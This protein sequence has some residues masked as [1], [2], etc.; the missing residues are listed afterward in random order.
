MLFLQDF[1]LTFLATPRSQM[2]PTDTLSWK[3]KIGTSND[4][5]DVVL[6]PSVLFIKAINVV[7]ANKITYS[8]LSDLLIS[9]ALYAL[10]DG[11]SLLTRASKHDWHYD[12]GKLY[13]KDRLYIAESAWQ[14]SILTIY[15]SETCGHGGVFHTLNLVQ[16]DYWWPGMTTY[17]CKY[18][19][20]YVICQANKVNTHPTVPA[21]SSLSSDYTHPF[22][23]V[24]VDL[25]TN[26]PPSGSFDSIMIIVDHGLIK[27]VIFC[28]CNKTIDAVGVAKLFFLHVFCH[29]GLHDKCISDQGPQ[30][31]L[32][33]ARELA[34]LLKYDLKLSF[35]SHTQT[36]GETESVNQELET[37]LHIFCNRHSKKWTDLLP[38]AEFSYNSTTHSTTNKS[39]FSLIL[40]YEL[41][42]YSPIGKT[43]IPALEIH[44]RE[45]EE[46]RKEALAAHE[47]AWRTMKEQISSKFC[48]WRSGDKVWLE[49]KNLKLH[50]PSKKLTSRREGPFEITQVIS[51]MA[52][53]LWLPLTWKIHDV[54]HASLLSSYRE[55]SEHSTN[56]SNPPPDLIREE[57]EYKIDKILSHCEIQGWRQ[58]LVSWKEYS[59]AENTWKPER[60]LQH[61]QTLLKA[62]KLWHPKEFPSSTWTSITMSIPTVPVRT[63]NYLPIYA[64]C[65]PSVQRRILFAFLLQN[66]IAT[67]MIERHQEF[68]N[69]TM[70]EL[71]HLFQIYCTICLTYTCLCPTDVPPVY[72]AAIQ[73][74]IAEVWASIL[75]LLHEERFAYIVN[76]L[77]RMA[78]SPILTPLFQEMSEVDFHLYFNNI[79]V[80]NPPL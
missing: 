77:P 16:R 58:Y 46:F 40:K 67:L 10:D 9:A 64:H 63:L 3:N 32:A 49:G 66:P 48:L 1:D 21:L 65:L 39:P 37:Y 75:D 54:F 53:K 25:I 24:S 47:K 28:P 70:I 76:D 78:V 71:C 55:T 60:N 26:L 30:F 8:F 41:R 43:F 17:I 68:T 56:F 36:D 5:Q 13:F 59:I 11:K 14:D 19:A 6:L 61:M 31:A 72:I 29:Y 38:M 74:A 2:G 35:T 69:P 15:A 73:T 51:S 34:C 80:P 44:L 18:V 79:A 4:N 45:L 50:Y 62:Y 33:F 12:N 23:Q 52:Y 27:G 42:S 20:D 57:E 7:L 22:Q